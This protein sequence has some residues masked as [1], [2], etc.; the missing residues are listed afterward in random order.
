MTISQFVLR[1]PSIAPVGRYLDKFPQGTLSG[2]M[3]VCG[4]M[5]QI[6][7]TL[8]ISSEDMA[9]NCQGAK[10]VLPVAAAMSDDFVAVVHGGQ[11]P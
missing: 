1:D 2:A 11:S 5:S 7:Q 10:D 4:E 9:G 8:N 6:R 3:L